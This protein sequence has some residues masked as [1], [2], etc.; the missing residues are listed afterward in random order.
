VHGAGIDAE[1]RRGPQ[2]GEH[3]AGSARVV[4]LRRTTCFQGV[5][6]HSGRASQ[7]LRCDEIPSDRS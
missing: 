4:A 2:A 3:R 7:N 5:T 1:N 6:R